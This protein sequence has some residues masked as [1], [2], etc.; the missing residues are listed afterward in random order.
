MMRHWKRRVEMVTCDT[1]PVKIVAGS[2]DEAV[3]EKVE[4][5]D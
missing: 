3:V 1:A 4:L 2:S 5:A